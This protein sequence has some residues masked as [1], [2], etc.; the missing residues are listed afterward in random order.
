MK[1]S[2]CLFL[3]GPQAKNGFYIFRWL[4][5]IK[6]RIFHDIGTLYEIHILE[7]TNKILLEHSHH[8]DWLICSCVVSGF[9]HCN[10]RLSSFKR[11]HLAG[12]P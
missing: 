11:D 12:H 2:H 1:C 6:E 9:S 7:S 8:S 3:Y 5:K 10:T 4:Q